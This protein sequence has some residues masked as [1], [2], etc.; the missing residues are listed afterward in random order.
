MAGESFYFEPFEASFVNM[1]YDF[2]NNVS[3]DTVVKVKVISVSSAGVA[4]VIYLNDWK[5]YNAQHF[6]G[7]LDTINIS[8]LSVRI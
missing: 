5:E 6:R 2:Q 8:L 1:L 3:T 7:Q 4:L